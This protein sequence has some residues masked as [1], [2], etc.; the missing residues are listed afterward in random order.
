MEEIITKISESL[1][2]TDAEE[3]KSLSIFDEND[4]KVCAIGK[5]KVA[6]SESATIRQCLTMQW[7][8]SVR[9]KIGKV[10]FLCLRVSNAL[11]GYGNFNEPNVDGEIIGSRITRKRMLLKDVKLKRKRLIELLLVL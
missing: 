3:Q 10:N 4:N 1:A 2:L 5:P 7:R 8:N 6:E 9:I 11:F